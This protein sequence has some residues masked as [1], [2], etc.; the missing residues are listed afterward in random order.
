M[1]QKVI[2][3]DL[4]GTLIDFVDYSFEGSREAVEKVK[5]E[6]IPIVFCSSKTKAEQQYYVDKLEIKDPF[7]TEN[8]SAIVIPKGYFQFA[9]HIDDEDDQFHYII[10]GQP[11]HRILEVISDMKRKLGIEATGYNDLT[12]PEIKEII[13][14]STAFSKRAANREYSETILKHNA[15]E[16]QFDEMQEYLSDKGLLLQSGGKFHTVIGDSA[17]KGK[18]VIKLI[19][20]YQE[21]Y[22]GDVISFGI[23]DSAND[24]PLLQSVD[25]GFQVQKPGEE[26][27]D[28]GIEGI[29]KIAGVGPEGWTLAAEVILQS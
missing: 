17:D 15:T 19:N 8:G 10:L 27:S 29:E 5:Q 20:L 23:G 28:L 12:L 7:I 21:Q 26:W 11:R 24:V 4:D 16:Q 1:S 25:A 3:T 22:E 13:K 2:F 9:Y 14:L 18:A 6:E